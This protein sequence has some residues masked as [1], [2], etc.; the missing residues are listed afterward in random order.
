MDVKANYQI[1]LKVKINSTINDKNSCLKM[2]VL[3]I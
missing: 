1:V 3:P 2:E